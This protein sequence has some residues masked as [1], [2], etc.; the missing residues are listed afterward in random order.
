MFKLAT[1]QYPV[2]GKLLSGWIRYPVKWYPAH[3]YCWYQINQDWWIQMI[4]HQCWYR[5]TSIAV[6]GVAT[7]SWTDLISVLLNA[8]TDH[9]FFRV[10]LVAWVQYTCLQRIMGRVN[11]PP[12]V[13]KK[14][15]LPQ[16]ELITPT[17]SSWELLRTSAW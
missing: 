12:L 17:G 1:I 5:L 16:F 3:P 9:A 15:I 7:L 10:Y 4:R 11:N 2:S 8:V 6:T 13:S 14:Y